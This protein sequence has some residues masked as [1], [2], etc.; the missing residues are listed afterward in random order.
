MT[1]LDCGGGLYKS[2]YTNSNVLYSLEQLFNLDLNNL[3]ERDIFNTNVNP[4][5]YYTK[6]IKQ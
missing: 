2:C 3:K 4:F 5:L 6:L 1:V